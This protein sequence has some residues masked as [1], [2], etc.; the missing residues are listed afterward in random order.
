MGF[1]LTNSLQLIHKTINHISFHH[2]LDI[3]SKQ[4][5]VEFI[6]IIVIP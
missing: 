5:K 1:I 3:V 4:N 6:L 2:F